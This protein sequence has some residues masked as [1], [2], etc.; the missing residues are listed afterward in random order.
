MEGF[1][2][3]DFALEPEEL[4]PH[5]WLL[6]EVDG[7]LVLT[8]PG[9]DRILDVLP[10]KRPILKPPFNPVLSR[11]LLR[12]CLRMQSEGVRRIAIYGAGGH[13]EELLQW[14]LP[15]EFELVAIVTSDG[16]SH[17]TWDVPV[18]PLRSASSLELDALLLSSSSFEP[19][20]ISLAEQAGARRVIPLYSDWPADFWSE[21]SV[22]WRR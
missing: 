7:E 4:P 19:E 22:S 3:R 11:R 8:E 16:A 20:M 21:P 13:T 10:R 1:T 6:R 18:V 5:T 2:L 14:G 17:R 9:C 15:D 12:A